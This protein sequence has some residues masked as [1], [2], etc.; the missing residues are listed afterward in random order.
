MWQDIS[1]TDTASGW[2]RPDSPP[3]GVDLRRLATGTVLNVHTCHSCYRVVVVEDELRHERSAEYERLAAT[4]ELSRRLAPA[5]TDT[6]VSMGRV[7]GTAGLAI[8]LLLFGL[9]LYAAMP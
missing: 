3:S 9:I 4:G 6:L 5:P 1:S 8:G 7:V 2:I